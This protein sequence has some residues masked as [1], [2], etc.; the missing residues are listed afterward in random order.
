MLST[1][2]AGVSKERIADYNDLGDL[3]I[4]CSISFDYHNYNNINLYN[5]NIF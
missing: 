1:L 4:D 5:F 2:K 3:G